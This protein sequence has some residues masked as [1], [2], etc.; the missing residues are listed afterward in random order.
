MNGKL[1]LL[2]LLLSP[3]CMQSSDEEKTVT[4]KKAIVCVCSGCHK[5]Q[6]GAVQPKNEKVQQYDEWLIRSLEVHSLGLEGGRWSGGPA[7]L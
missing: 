5:P 2:F 4:Q 7:K 6:L 3:L 1:F